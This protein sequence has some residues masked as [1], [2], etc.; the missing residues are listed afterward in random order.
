MFDNQYHA[1]YGNWD[2]NESCTRSGKGLAEME[3]CGGEDV[4]FTMYNAKRKDCCADGSIAPSG[5]C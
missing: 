5:T 4:H 1:F 2:A 3:C